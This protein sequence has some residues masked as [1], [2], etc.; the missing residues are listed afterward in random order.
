VSRHPLLIVEDDQ[1]IRESLVEFLQDNGYR[2]DA[3]RDGREALDHLRHA[4]ERPG[5]IVLDLMMPVMDGQQFRAEQLRNPELAQIPVLLIS[6]YRDVEERAAG[7]GRL[8]FLRKPFD[9]KQLL[10]EVEARC[11]GSSSPAPR[12]AGGSRS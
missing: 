11:R 4:Q 1:D 8:P 5:L 2:V 7:L 9:L 3:A 10:E 12:S 6:A